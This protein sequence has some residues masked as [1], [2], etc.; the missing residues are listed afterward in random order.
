[1]LF[2]VGKTSIRKPV[3]A[4]K[5]FLLLL[6]KLISGMI[7]R[8]LLSLGEGSAQGAISQTIVGTYSIDISL[9]E[10]GLHP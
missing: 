3:D 2:K 8:N 7:L 6:S 1:M 9:S 5:S 4:G 10:N